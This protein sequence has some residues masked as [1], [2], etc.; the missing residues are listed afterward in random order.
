MIKKVK[1]LVSNKTIDFSLKDQSKIVK[2]NRN[3]YIRKSK[4]KI[5][6]DFIFS[7]IANIYKENIKED[8]LLVNMY[9]NNIISLK[10]NQSQNY[11]FLNLDK[12][13]SPYNNFGQ[14]INNITFIGPASEGSKF[15]HHTLS[16]P[17]K[18]QFNIMDLENWVNRL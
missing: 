2:K 14:K 1:K 4:Y 17:D 7:A 10:K 9:K 12:N 16:R 5:K 11:S 8:R 3:L 6:I 13:Q 15:F 18:K